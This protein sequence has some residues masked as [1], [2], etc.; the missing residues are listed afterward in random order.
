MRNG[1][2]ELTSVTGHPSAISR[3]SV[4]AW[5]KLPSIS[6]TRAPCTSACASLPSATFPLGIR[7]AHVMPARP[8]YAAADA[9][10]LPVDAQ[11]T[12]EEPS[13]SAFEIASV[14][15]RSLNDPV[16]LRPSYFSQTSAPVSSD[17]LSEWTSGVP[18]SP[19]VTIGVASDTGRWSNQRRMIPRRPSTAAGAVIVRT[20][21]PH[22]SSSA[23]P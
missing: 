15:P 3:V 8:A 11:T 20:L 18:P 9:L 19:S 16:G 5:S 17:N 7:T 1:L 13:S 22:G 4:R 12:A 2:T 21:L 10:V 6:S 14:I 23:R